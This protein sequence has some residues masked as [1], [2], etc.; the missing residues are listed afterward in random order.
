MIHGFHFPFS[1]ILQYLQIIDKEFNIHTGNAC[2]CPLTE[3]TFIK[4]IDFNRFLASLHRGATFK[5]NISLI[6]LSMIAIGKY[7]MFRK[8]TQYLSG[9][10]AEGLSGSVACLMMTWYVVETEWLCSPR[11]TRTERE[12]RY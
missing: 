6:L 7:I 10:V 8:A 11:S 2:L 4:Y 1:S 5:I 3:Q 12:S 9:S